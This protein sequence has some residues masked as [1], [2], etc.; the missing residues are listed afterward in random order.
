MPLTQDLY[1]TDD[2]LDHGTAIPDVAEGDAN[3]TNREEGN[4]LMT[5]VDSSTDAHD[6]VQYMAEEHPRI[7]KG[8]PSWRQ[9]LREFDYSTVEEQGNVLSVLFPEE[10]APKWNDPGEAT[11][12]ATPARSLWQS[13]T[14][15][16][17]L[18]EERGE[19]HDR[20]TVS[21]AHLNAYLMQ[22]VSETSPLV[23]LTRTVY[24]PN[25]GK[26]KEW[27]AVRLTIGEATELAHLLLLLVDIATDTPDEIGGAPD[28]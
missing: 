14:S 7:P 22:E 4:D 12:S 19:R 26:W 8:S 24:L 2:A 1:E 28:A 11:E 25:D 5:S 18:R 13:L 10:Q 21:F 15:R 6:F 27:H 9:H 23:N 3:V 17:I 20:H 16:L